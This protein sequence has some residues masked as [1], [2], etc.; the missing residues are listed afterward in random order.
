M[1]YREL[2]E[3]AFIKNLITKVHPS[4]V[5]SVVSDSFDFWSVITKIAPTLKDEILNRQPNALGLAK[6]VFRPD[7]GDPVKIICG[8][9]VFEASL[10]D[11]LTQSEQQVIY[12]AYVAGK[13]YE[14]VKQS[15]KYYEISVM[16]K[17]GARDEPVILQGNEVSEAEV[18]GAVEC[19][20]DIFGGTETDKGFKVLHERVGL[21]YGDS[22][23]LPRA[24]EILRRLAEKGFASCNVV[25]GIGSF[26]YQYHTRDTFGWAMKATWC[27]VDG[28]PL[29]IFKDPATDSGTKKSA[30][31]LLRVEKENG[32]FVLYDQQTPEQEAQGELKVVFEDGKLVKE[33][34]LGEVRA[35]LASYL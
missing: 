5:V 27:E 30:K 3:K 31:G 29:D 13:P 21:I 8:Y 16:G 28:E 11:G 23:T 25:F 14:A 12:D 20:W 22:I 26:T 35:T 18:K 4:G 9:R 24:E 1:N 7:S 34:T 6:V 2:A 15:G 10:L 32:R 33:Y 17:G 19:L